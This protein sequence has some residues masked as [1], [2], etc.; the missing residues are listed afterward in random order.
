M[1]FRW[2]TWNWAFGHREGDRFAVVSTA[3]MDPTCFADPANPA[4]L[5]SRLR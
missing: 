3:R 1:C 5:H 4:L 2:L